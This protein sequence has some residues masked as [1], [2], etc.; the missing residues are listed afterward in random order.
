MLCVLSHLMDHIR[1][2][3]FHCDH[4]IPVDVCSVL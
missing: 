1:L 4:F 3:L 2:Q